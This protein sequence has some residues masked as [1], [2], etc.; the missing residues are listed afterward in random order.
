[1]RAEGVERG[2]PGSVLVLMEAHVYILSIWR[3]VQ[4]DCHELRSEFGLAWASEQ[5]PV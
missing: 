1:M 3:V 2:E 5:D 4:E